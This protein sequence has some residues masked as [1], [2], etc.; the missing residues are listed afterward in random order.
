[1][2]KITIPKQEYW[3]ART[4]EFVQLNAVTLRLEHSLVSLS[5]WEMKW[6]VPFFGNDS[7]TREQMVDYVR[8]MTVTQGV[9]PS[10]YLR[11]TESNMP[12]QLFGFM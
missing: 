4:Q 12:R 8:C 9:E 6:H 11:L 7:L 5:K 2:L 10:V 3:D 1:M